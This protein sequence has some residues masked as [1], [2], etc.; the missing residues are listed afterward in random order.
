MNVRDPSLWHPNVLLAA[1][2]LMGLKDS[3]A[4]AVNRNASMLVASLLT[5]KNENSEPA[6]LEVRH[7]DG[8]KAKITLSLSRAESEGDGPASGGCPGPRI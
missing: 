7:A 5:L 8:A 4:S 2:D 3:R 1:A 6:M